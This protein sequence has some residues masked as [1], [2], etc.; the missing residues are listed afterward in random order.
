MHRLHAWFLGR[1]AVDD[2]SWAL[3]LLVLGGWSAATLPGPVGWQHVGRLAVG[4]LFAGLMLL[5]RAH[6]DTAVLVAVALGGGQLLGGA[7]AGILIVGY[8]VLARWG[9]C[10]GSPRLALA[11]LASALSVGPLA[12]WRGVADGELDRFSAWDRVSIAAL[13]SLPF[14]LCWAWGWWA[15]ARRAEL[16]ELAGRAATARTELGRGAARTRMALE[17]HDVITHDLTAMTVQAGG[18][19]HVLPA[20]PHLARDV[21]RGIGPQGRR[22]LVELERLKRVLIP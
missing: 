21:V 16:A 15:R 14:L 13:Y 19:E 3:C 9:A 17:L 18:A 10:S 5:R 22:I 8:L 12:V 7:Q 20:G 6:P 11:T 1:P 2:G 4:V